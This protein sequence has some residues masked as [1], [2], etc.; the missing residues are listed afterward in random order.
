MAEDTGLHL[1]PLHPARAGPRRDRLHFRAHAATLADSAPV[2]ALDGKTLRGSLDR[3]EDVKA[4]QVLSA[5]AGR[6]QIV[7]GQ[8]LIEDEGKDHE[9]QAA[10]RLIETLG[11]AGRLY[12][13]DALHL[14]KKRLRP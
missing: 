1:H 6:E 3:F 2:I 14:Q 11:L 10:Q 8:V 7:L 4:A 5:F 12:T 13:F 9:I